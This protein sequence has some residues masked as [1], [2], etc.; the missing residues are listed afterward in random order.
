MPAIAKRIMIVDEWRAEAEKLFGPDEMLW[1][2]K[3]PSCGHECSIQDYKDAGAKSENV[4]FSCIG[5]WTGTTQ[6]AFTGGPG[7][8]NYAGGG[9]I[10][11]NPVTV[12]D[13]ELTHH[14]FEFGSKV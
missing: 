1:R 13:G 9:L 10:G 2:F 11:I 8:C 3:C 14:L 5:R 7:P 12:T 4:G 6:D